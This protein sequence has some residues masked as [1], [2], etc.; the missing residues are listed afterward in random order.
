MPRPKLSSK[1]LARLKSAF[2][3]ADCTLRDLEGTNFEIFHAELPLRTHVLVNPYYLQLGTMLV[4]KPVNRRDKK[5][6]AIHAYL[7]RINKQA[8]LA[9]FVLNHE[10]FDSDEGGWSIFACVRFVTGKI[11][12]NYEPAALKNMITIWF[13]DLANLMA[14]P[15][16]FEL[17][18]LL[19]ESAL[20]PSALSA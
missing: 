6:G 18:A 7:S 9:K 11:G 4:A 17:C 12:G 13:Y 2:R 3:A 16:P 1:Q 20:P 14:A 15:E 5:P 19:E 10:Q 8:N